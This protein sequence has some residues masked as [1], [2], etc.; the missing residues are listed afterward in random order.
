M[1]VPGRGERLLVVGKSAFEGGSSGTDVEPAVAG[2]G[3]GDIGS[4]DHRLCETFTRGGA[5][6]FV[7]AVTLPLVLCGCFSVSKD[8]G[9]MSS[10]DPAEV[11]HTGVRQFEVS[12]VK[13]PVEVLMVW[14]EG[15]DDDVV[16]GSG[17][18]VLQGTVE[19]RV[20]PADFS[21]PAAVR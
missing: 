5:L 15:T 10:D 13:Q 1:L 7:P 6:R 2:I 16:E 4:V 3:R 12:G 11:W 20:E 17:E 21:P 8:F 14:V 19:R 9:I 18:V